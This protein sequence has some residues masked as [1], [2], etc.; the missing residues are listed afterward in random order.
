MFATLF[1]KR[2][3][4]PQEPPAEVPAPEAGPEWTRFVA[5]HCQTILGLSPASQRSIRRALKRFGAI[6]GP[7]SPAAVRFVDVERFVAALQA[8]GLAPATINKHLRHLSS[9]FNAAIDREYI[10]R[11]PVRRR[12]FQRVPKKLIRVLSPAEQAELLGACPNEVWRTFLY[13][14]LHTGVRLN[15]LR[16]ITWDDLDLDLGPGAPEPSMKV[17]PQKGV[18][19]RRVPL[20]TNI[21]QKLRRLKIARRQLD[22]GP[23][24]G[25]VNSTMYLHFHRI[26]AR[27]GIQHCTLADVRQTFGASA[28]PAHLRR[29]TRNPTRVLS[30]AEQTAVLNACLSDEWRVLVCLLLT[31]GLPREQLCRARWNDFDFLSESPTVRVDAQRGF[32]VA[33]HCVPIPCEAV[34]HLLKLRAVKL[35]LSGPF[36][37]LGSTS[38]VQRIFRRILARSGIKRCTLHDMRRTFCSRLAELD[39]N[40]TTIQSLAGHASPATTALYYQRVK[41]SAQRAAVE[42]LAAA[43]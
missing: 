29:Q 21:V 39:V 33:E 12:H 34:E 40:Q 42:R 16:P 27:A 22:G 11:S 38:T 28:D 26:V 6:I 2:S 13:T 23:L 5:E 7:A 35:C 17:C 15:Q 24:V 4:R 9:A 36:I 25:M 10:D 3:Q 41:P 14:L 1:R 32:E 19:E 8:R 20:T 31:T 37:G 43:G 18:D 30:P